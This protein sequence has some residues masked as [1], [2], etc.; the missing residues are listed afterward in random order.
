MSGKICEGSPCP[1]LHVSFFRKPGF[2]HLYLMNLRH[3]DH[4]CKR[5]V[6]RER[7]FSIEELK[8]GH[9]I[10]TRVVCLAEITH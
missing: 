6:E 2:H 10:N 3:R 5:T 8:S 7:I 1:A 9:L 4:I